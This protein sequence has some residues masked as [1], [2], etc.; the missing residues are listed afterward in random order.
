MTNTGTKAGSLDDFGGATFT[1]IEAYAGTANSLTGST[2]DD[3]IGITG[4]D[5]V[6][7]NGTAM[8]GIDAVD[9][10][11]LAADALAEINAEVVDVMRTDT[12]TELSAVAGASPDLHT[13]VQFIFMKVRNKEEP[14]TGP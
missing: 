3:T 7:I 9:A 11:A 1:E 10:D 8:T 14:P 12:A 5:E 2:G 13:M 6:S 4:A